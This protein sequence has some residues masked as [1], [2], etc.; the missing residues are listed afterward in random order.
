MKKLRPRQ[1]PEMYEGSEAFDRFQQAVRAVLKV[2]K[3]AM[4]PSPFAKQKP[5]ASKG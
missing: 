5:A 3:S 2:P 1:H 4:P